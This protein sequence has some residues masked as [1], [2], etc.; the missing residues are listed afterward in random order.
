MR[1][2]IAGRYDWHTV[3]HVMALFVVSSPSYSQKVLDFELY[4]RTTWLHASYW[5]AVLYQPETNEY[6]DPRQP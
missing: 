6:F 2:Q 3:W 1:L 4:N 5:C